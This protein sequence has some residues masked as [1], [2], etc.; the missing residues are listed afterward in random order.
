VARGA[1]ATTWS[2]RSRVAGGG[3]LAGMPMANISALICREQERPGG[4]SPPG[5]MTPARRWRAHIRVAALSGPTV[6]RWPAAA[7]PLAEDR[8]YYVGRRWRAIAPKRAGRPKMPP[9]FVCSSYERVL[10]WFFLDAPVR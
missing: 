2:F 10:A 4:E 9:I 8:V 5:S 3:A 7:Y 6:R 1:T